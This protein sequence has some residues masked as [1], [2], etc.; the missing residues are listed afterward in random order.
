MLVCSIFLY[1][2]CESVRKIIDHV[3]GMFKK[4]FHILR[5]PMLVKKMSEVEQIV[6]VYCVLH[7]MGMQVSAFGV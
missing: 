3:F 5:L 6:K 2:R 4:L 7:N 1:V